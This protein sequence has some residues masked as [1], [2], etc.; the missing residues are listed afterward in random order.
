VPRLIRDGR[1]IRPALGIRAAPPAFGEAL[2]FP[3]GAIVLGV[4]PGSPAATAGLR[5]FVRAPAE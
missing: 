4:V 5:P 2:G 3:D 1:F